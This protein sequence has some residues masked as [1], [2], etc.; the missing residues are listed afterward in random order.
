MVRLLLDQEGLEIG[1]SPIERLLARRRS[2]IRM[3]RAAI[4][5]LQLTDDP[6]TWL[7]G[8]RSPGTHVPGVVA[9]GRWRATSGDDFVLVRGRR[10]DGIVLSLDEDQEF[11]RIILSTAHGRAL[12]DALRIDDVSRQ[13]DVID[14]A[15]E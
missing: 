12:V 3:P 1:L 7:R 13:T 4:E 8:V 10:F 6:W 2:S 14:L 9:A 5:R 11:Q 15:R